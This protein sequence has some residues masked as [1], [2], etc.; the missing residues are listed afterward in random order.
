MERSIQYIKIAMIAVLLIGMMNISDDVF[1]MLK[2][3]AMGAFLWIAYYEYLYYREF[4]MIIYGGLAILYQPFLD[5]GINRDYWFVINLLAAVWLAYSFYMDKFNPR[6][7]K[8][9]KKNQKK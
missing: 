5:F 4:R 1:N 3:V 7:R 9:K 2:L 6:P 8:I